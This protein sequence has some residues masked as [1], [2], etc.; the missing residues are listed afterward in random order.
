MSAATYGRSRQFSGVP[1]PPSDWTGW[2]LPANQ[3][4]PISKTWGEYITLKREVFLDYLASWFGKLGDV[5]EEY[6]MFIILLFLSLSAAAIPGIFFLK[7][8]NNPASLWVPRDLP[9]WGNYVHMQE[10]YGGESRQ[11]T[12]IVERRDGEDVVEW[13]SMREVSN[14]CND[15]TPLPPTP[16]LLTPLLLT[17][18]TLPPSR[19]PSSDTIP[20][21]LRFHDWVTQGITTDYGGSTSKEYG[22]QDFCF[23]SFTDP[24]TLQTSSCSAANFLAVWDYN[25]SNIPLD[26]RE[27]IGDL[28]SLNR[29]FPITTSLGGVTYA[30][31]GKTVIAAKSVR[32]AY[33]YRAGRG[34][35]VE[36]VFYEQMYEWEGSLLAATTAH[37]DSSTLPASYCMDCYNRTHLKVSRLL[38]RS[39]DDEA[40]RLIL[41]DAPL[42][43]M[44]IVAIVLWLSLTFGTMNR[45]ESRFLVSWVVLLE[46]VC[47]LTFA[48]GVLGYFCEFGDR[49]YVISSL[50]AM[51]PFV[52]AGVSVDDMIVIEDFFNKCEG[53]PG[54]VRETMKAAGIAISTTS[55]TTIVAFFAGSY[56]SMPG[57]MRYV[58]VRAIDRP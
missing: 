24:V 35:F 49:P 42:F 19:P 58:R 6:P 53:K 54:R 18:F 36:E 29:K 11:A 32:L 46:M 28:N 17:P 22:F 47:C 8:E 26:S 4:V 9:I 48:F 30:P 44:A 34:E 40:T 43:V 27:I 23:H 16:L 14:E 41:Q 1:L 5:I 51:I 37:A 50:N 25:A 57:V 15:R 52:L 12:F 39:V 33:S 10:N 13:E 45:V 3:P 7:I 21:I 38:R 31:D 2:S 56:T 55:V 20:Q